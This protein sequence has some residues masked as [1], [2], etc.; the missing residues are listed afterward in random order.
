M[1]VADVAGG[2]TGVGEE[3]SCAWDGGESGFLRKLVS[4]LGKL[5]MLCFFFQEER[6]MSSILGW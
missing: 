3:V 5:L 1:A 2:Y 4:K 6:K